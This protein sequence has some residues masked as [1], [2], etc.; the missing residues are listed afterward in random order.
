[1]FS[2][3]CACVHV[4]DVN[5][6]VSSVKLKLVVLQSHRFMVPTQYFLLFTTLSSEIYFIVVVFCAVHVWADPKGTL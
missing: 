2:M 4:N 3:K 5:S 6:H 1:M